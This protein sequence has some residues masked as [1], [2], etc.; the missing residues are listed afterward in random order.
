MHQGEKDCIN[1]LI[2]DLLSITIYRGVL[3][4]PVTSMLLD[5]LREC[6][7]NQTDLVYKHWGQLCAILLTD[8]GLKSLKQAIAKEVLADENVFTLK[9]AKSR[10]DNLNQDLL[11][12]AKR[13]LSILYMAASKSTDLI[14]SQ[15]KADVSLPCWD[16]TPAEYPLS[17]KWDDCINEL[18]EFHYENGVGQFVFCNAFLWRNRGL[19]AITHH[20][21]IKLVNLKGY[22][23]QKS[24]VVNN[25]LA[26][27]DGFEANN[28]LLYGDRGTG[29]SSTVKALLNEYA[30]RKLRM[31][32]VPK[33]SLNE[34][35]VLTAKLSNIPMKF[36]IFIDDLSFSGND[37][38]FAA[39]K[40][41]LEG[42][43]ASRPDNV[44]IYATSNRR[45]LL[46]ETFSDRS[47][48]EIHLADTVQ[49]SISLSDRFG[50]FVTFLIPDKQHFLEIVSQMAEDRN[51]NIDRQTLLALAEK[52]AIER[53]GR[54][55]RYARQFISDL[56]ARMCRG[57]T[58]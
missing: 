48:N 17:N 20:D 45:H 29:K 56:Q 36:I 15:I 23:T 13:D 33:E 55:P 35:P 18:G 7:N 42:G 19:H 26:F 44:L 31:I 12:M 4:K 25:T 38:N 37:D 40:A 1:K 22:E 47:G 11:K 46:R 43:L 41:V 39:L 2:R 28:V 53:G 51:L 6:H 5:L 27:L 57:E 24:I 8:K 30:D 50:L 9:L 14:K 58:F 52:W 32:E 16:N 54:S 34:L 3:Q 10:I 49:E 21:P